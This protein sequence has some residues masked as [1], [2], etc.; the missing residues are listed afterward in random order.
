MVYFAIEI[1]FIWVDGIFLATTLLWDMNHAGHGIISNKKVLLLENYLTKLGIIPTGKV[2]LTSGNVEYQFFSIFFFLCNTQILRQKAKV[3]CNLLS[4]NLVVLCCH[5]AGGSDMRELPFH[6]NKW[7]AV[8][9][10]LSSNQLFFRRAFLWNNL[11]IFFFT[12]TFLSF[13]QTSSL[14]LDIKKKK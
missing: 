5:Q 11:L 1:Q 8:G 14:L 2:V 10:I 3:N 7:K 6:W 4:Q 9:T 12:V 13:P